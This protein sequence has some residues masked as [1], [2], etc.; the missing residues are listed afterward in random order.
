MSETLTPE[1]AYAEQI[2]RWAR[3]MAEAKN[4][5]VHGAI[6]GDC[7]PDQVEM[8]VE[9][10]VEKRWDKLK[11]QL[12]FV[13]GAFDD[14]EEL[15]KTYGQEVPLA[16]YD[17]GS[18]D[19]E[20]FLG[21]LAET[22]I[23]SGEQMDHVACQR[24]RFALEGEARKN[25]RGHVRFQEL[26]SVAETLAAELEQ[27]PGLQL[28]LNPIR[29]W[30]TFQTRALLDD[31]ATPPADAVFF[32]VAGE[33]RTAILDEQGKR[34]IEELAEVSPCSLGSWLSTTECGE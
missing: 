30:A 7:V 16:A 32:P 22:F 23:L 25:R 8:F 29:S 2:R 20:R 34:L 26:L 12:E 27:N 24:A 14:L 3:A 5:S 10:N 4:D 18:S 33:I 28:Y 1:K 31:V 9:G 17:T 13:A 6:A 21:W 11:R 19:G 15:I